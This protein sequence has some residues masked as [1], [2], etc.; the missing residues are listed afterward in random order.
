V[1]T[2]H[3]FTMNYI[4][5]MS[6]SHGCPRI[7]YNAGDILAA[8]DVIFRLADNANTF[9]SAGLLQVLPDA[10]LPNIEKLRVQK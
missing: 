10:Q 7:E 5:R 4:V 1:A 2:P 6:F 9:I 8:D 3:F